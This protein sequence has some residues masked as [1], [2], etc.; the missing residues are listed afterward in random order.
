MAVK[1]PYTPKKQPVIEFIPFDG[2]KFKTEFWQHAE[3]STYIGRIL[4]VHGFAEDSKMYCEYFDI[5]SDLGFDIFFFDQRGAGETSPEKDHGKTN[6]SLVYKDLEFIIKKNLESMKQKDPK[7]KLILMGHSMGGGIVLNYAVKGKYRD[8]IRAIVA[9]GPMVLLHPSTAPNFLLKT[10]SN[11]A[12]KLAPNF[13]LDAGLNI[14]YVTSN[15]KWQKYIAGHT[16]KFWITSNLFHG[17][18]HRGENLTKPEYVSSFDPDIPVLVFHGTNDQINWLDGT[19]KF[20]DLLHDNVDKEFV[21]IKNAR[22][23]LAV[24]VDPL[25]DQVIDKIVDYFKTH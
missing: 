8:Q 14:N 24:E 17:M 7:E 22:H 2:L 20:I 10:F 15:E 25:R 4:Y 21:P 1:V 9:T 6:E 16:K 12:Y 5:L 13:R 18:L 11:L 23:S 3:G 19:K